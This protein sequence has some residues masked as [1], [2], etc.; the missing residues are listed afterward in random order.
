MH[1]VVQIGQL[2]ELIECLCLEQLLQN[3]DG[4][5]YESRVNEANQGDIALTENPVYRQQCKQV[6][7]KYHFVTSVLKAGLAWSKPTVQ[8]MI[9]LQMY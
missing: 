7:I 2:N 8:L 3:N 9:R 4:L 5:K 6:D 1:T